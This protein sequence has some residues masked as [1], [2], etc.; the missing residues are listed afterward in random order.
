MKHSAKCS[1]PLNLYS[2]NLSKYRK[3]VP[4]NGVFVII[5]LMIQ[6]VDL[7]NSLQEKWNHLDLW[8]YNVL[9]NCKQRLMNYSSGL[10]KNA[11]ARELLIKRTF[12]AF[13]DGSYLQ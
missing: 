11:K 7:Q 10:E 5:N 3:L 13:S 6:S 4:A 2:R 8:I 12:Y 9:D 1:P